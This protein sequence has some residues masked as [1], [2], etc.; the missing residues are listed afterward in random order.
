[1]ELAAATQLAPGDR[2]AATLLERLRARRARHG[3]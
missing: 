3:E 2:D 1:V